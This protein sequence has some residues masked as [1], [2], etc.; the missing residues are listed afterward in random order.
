MPTFGGGKV[1][2]GKEIYNV[3][4]KIEQ[5]M[6]WIDHD[7]F[8]PFCGLLG[9]GIH[10]IKD[11]RC[12]DFCDVN[13][14]MIQMFQ[15][16]KNGWQLPEKYCSK[17]EYK[18]LRLSKEHSALR[19]FMGISCAYSG[20]FFS[21]YRPTSERQ[22]FYGNTR[23]GLMGMFKDISCDKITF[24][25]AR[26]YREF[27]PKGQTIYCDPPYLN[28]NLQSEHFDNFD[29]ESFWNTMREW[30]ESNLVFISEYKAPDDFEEVWCKKV[31]SVY[32]NK[33][34]KNIE[35][36]FMLKSCCNP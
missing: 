12:V 22:D 33:K 4:K 13:I 1:R 6:E 9:V 18:K 36:L 29:H 32:A 35:K 27:K 34:K 23:K 17:D 26:D 16:L 28:N 2:L 14:D 5:D 8:E 31:K 20:I 11:K 25:D 7:Y 19:G 21:G 15:E 3:I 10:A 24:K 30:S